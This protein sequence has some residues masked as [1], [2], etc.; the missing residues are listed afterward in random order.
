M[1]TIKLKVGSKV[2]SAIYT[3]DDASAPVC[4]VY[5]M[6]EIKGGSTDKSIARRLVACW[7]ACE[8]IST[9]NL[10][11]NLPVKE[12]AHR[13]NAA[14]RERDALLAAIAATTEPQRIAADLRIAAMKDSGE[15]QRREA[16]RALAEQIKLE[17]P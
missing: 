8:G 10:E 17:T 14:L 5:S 3:D 15:L 16:D 12:L 1:N 2:P 9:E 7:N 13:Y 4:I 6:G 11:G